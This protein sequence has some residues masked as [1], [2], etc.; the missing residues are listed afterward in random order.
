MTNRLKNFENSCTFETGQSDF[1][2]MTLN[3]LK[4]SF[5]KQK[6]RVLN[7]PNYDFYNNKFF[8]EQF[9]PKLNNNLSKQ[10]NSF[11]KFQKTCLTV[12]HL[13]T[14]VKH[15]FRTANQTP[16][17]NKKLNRAIKIRSKLRNKFLNRRSLTDENVYNKQINT[18]LKKR[19][20]YSNL[21]VNNAVDGKKFWKTIKTFFSDKSSNSE[22]ISS[23]EKDRVIIDDSKIAEIFNQYFSNT[24][25][26]LGL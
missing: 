17:M 12:L 18:R 25:Q 14:P 20:L 11:E 24:V 8:R 9:L 7:Y 4:S 15:K 22:K 23:I 6:D 10:N 19:Q 5:K 21:N 16:F 26:D 13:V 1:H 3:V 2:K